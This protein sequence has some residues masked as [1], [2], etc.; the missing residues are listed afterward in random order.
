MNWNSKNDFV[1]E[2]GYDKGIRKINKELKE[3]FEQREKEPE[4]NVKIWIKLANGENIM[5]N[6]TPEFNMVEISCAKE[7]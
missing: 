6:E 5:L 1:W 4:R 7:V 3:M 2:Y